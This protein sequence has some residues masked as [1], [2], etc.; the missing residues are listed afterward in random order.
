VPGA[1]D[2]A[3]GLVSATGRVEPRPALSA[4]IAGLRNEPIPRA[5]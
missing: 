4:L 5:A 3:R 1:L 2:G